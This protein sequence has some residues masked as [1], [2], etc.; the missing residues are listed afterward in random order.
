MKSVFETWAQWQ[1]LQWILRGGTVWPV[2]WYNGFLLCLPRGEGKGHSHVYYLRNF[3]SC[4]QHRSRQQTILW[5]AQKNGLWVTSTVCFPYLA[6][7]PQHPHPVTRPSGVLSPFW[8]QM[9]VSWCFLVIIFFV[10][11]C[12]LDHSYYSLY[13]GSLDILSLGLLLSKY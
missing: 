4:L 1:Y 13:P 12:N 5:P 7:F 8:G 3:I 9:C 6:R 2:C 11:L 10:S